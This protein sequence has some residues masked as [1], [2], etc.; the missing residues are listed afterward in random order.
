[1]LTSWRVPL[2]AR[3]NGENAPAGQ[4]WRRGWRDRRREERK[5]W[6]RKRI[7]LHKE[8]VYFPAWNGEHKRR[9]LM[10]LCSVCAPTKG[11]S[12]TNIK[13]HSVT[14]IYNGRVATATCTFQ[15][16]EEASSGGNVLKY[17]KKKG[18]KERNGGR[19]QESFQLAS[20]FHKNSNRL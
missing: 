17:V 20:S 13:T 18:T 8:A 14:S 1:M 16:Q 2:P 5:R 12:V 7:V 15:A 6:E 10:L 3:A 11:C 9:C 19:K 4:Q